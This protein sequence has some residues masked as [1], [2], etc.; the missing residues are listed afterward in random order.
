MLKIKSFWQKLP[1]SKRPNSKSFLNLQLAINDLV[2]PAK[3]SFFSFVAE[4]LQP[5]FVKYQTNDP[6]VP[7]FH[8]DLFNIIK[9]IM[10]LIVKPDIMVK[11]FNGADLKNFDLFNKD[12]FMEPKDMIVDFST[13][14]PIADLRKKI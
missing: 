2:T 8:N 7:Y 10:N 13:T 11:C 14:A 12:N 6:M 3:L 1:K 9:K 4:I 5:F